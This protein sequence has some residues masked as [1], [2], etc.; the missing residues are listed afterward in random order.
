MGENAYSIRIVS[1][2]VETENEIKIG[3]IESEKLRVCECRWSPIKR[4]YLH[5]FIGK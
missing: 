1:K 3:E 2:S 4:K 5:P